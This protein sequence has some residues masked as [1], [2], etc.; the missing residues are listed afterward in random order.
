MVDNL[1]VTMPAA[2]VVAE[3]APAAEAVVGKSLMQDKFKKLFKTTR[4]Q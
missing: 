3:D 4:V 2:E 1:L